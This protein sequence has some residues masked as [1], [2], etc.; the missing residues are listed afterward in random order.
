MRDEGELRLAA[1]QT[2]AFLA[3]SVVERRR[4]DLLCQDHYLERHLIIVGL[5]QI[6][7]I[8]NWPL[9]LYLIVSKAKPSAL[10]RTGRG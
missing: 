4:K 3:N 10:K 2:G 1:E 5:K 9:I 6:G 7:R 8:T